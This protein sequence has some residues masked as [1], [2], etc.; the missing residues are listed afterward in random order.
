MTPQ[1]PLALYHS[2]P[3]WERHCR[4]DLG[5]VHDGPSPAVPY[6][7]V[8]QD[9]AAAGIGVWRC[10]L[11]SARLSWSPVVHRLFGVDPARTPPRDEVLTI[12]TEESRVAMERLR[13]HAL[14]HHRGFTIDVA[15]R[16]AGERQRW[17]R[18]NAAPRVG[19]GC[20]VELY[21]TKQDV[22]AAY[23]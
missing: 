3:L 8:A 9:I 13:D 17:V 4:F 12:Y 7:I 16:V 1:E 23:R 6:D 20:A 18:I 10:D 2:W 15:L 11:L 14:R 19:D 22:T 5:R 21:G